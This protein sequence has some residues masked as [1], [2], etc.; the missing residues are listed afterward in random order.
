MHALRSLRS[1][2]RAR[3]ALGEVRMR[4]DSRSEAIDVNELALRIRAHEAVQAVLYDFATR[5]LIIRYDTRRGAARLL[6]GALSDWM[7]AARPKAESAQHVLRLTV[8]HELEGRLRLRVG[9]AP[10]RVLERLASFVTA[11]EGVE[12][13]MPSP[14]TGSLLVLFDAKVTTAKGLLDAITQV[15]P[16]AW[17]AATPPGKPAHVEW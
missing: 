7:D 17:P 1:S 15:P 11:M 6:R 5:S 2:T 10:P 16:S 12:R 9:D 4:V 3:N 14:A 8:D 13:A